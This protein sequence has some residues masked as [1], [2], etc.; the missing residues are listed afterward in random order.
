MTSD[1]LGTGLGTVHAVI[2][3]GRDTAAAAAFAAGAICRI[4]RRLGPLLATDRELLEQVPSLLRDRGYR[5]STVV[6]YTECVVRYMIWRH[7]RFDR[8]E[9]HDVAG[10]LAD[11][12]EQGQRGA[13]LRLHLAALRTVLDRL[14]DQRATA[15]IRYAARPPC[16]PP[17]RP[18]D[19][20][21]LL[22][23]AAGRDALLVSLAAKVGLRPSELSTLRWRQVDIEESVIQV[24]RGRRGRTVGL[25]LPADVTARL[26]AYKAVTATSEDYV[27]PGRRA[28]SPLAV[29]SVQ[30]ALNRLGSRCGVGVTFTRLTAAARLR[31][32]EGDGGIKVTVSAGDA[33]YRP[34]LPPPCIDRARAPPPSA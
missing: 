22:S 15:G 18:A 19:I 7:V 6:R 32:P 13:V 34:T 33:T 28:R 25:A 24:V 23:E 21:R 27:F 16:T 14:L 30:L 29:R 11:L 8:A 10:F 12:R 5:E 20:R 4:L 9:R 3:A 17:A 26:A 2:L 1:T 31:A